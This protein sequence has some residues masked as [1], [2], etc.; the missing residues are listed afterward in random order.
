MDALC[1]LVRVR[2]V[3]HRW[4]IHH[5]IS[6]QYLAAYASEMA[7]REDNRRQPNGKQFLMIAGAVMAHPV[8]AQWKGYWQRSMK[9]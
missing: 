5:H 9:A 8:S 4:Q 7:W 1:H 2:R 3:L 6:G